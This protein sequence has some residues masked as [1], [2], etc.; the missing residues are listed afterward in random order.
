MF[1]LQNSSGRGPL[2]KLLSTYSQIK[3]FKLTMEHG[4]CPSMLFSD[5]SMTYNSKQFALSELGKKL[6]RDN[7]FNEEKAIERFCGAYEIVKKQAKNVSL[8]IHISFLILKYL[9]TILLEIWL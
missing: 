1:K 9:N 4:I 3:L 2:S 8:F 6:S 5:I 7:L